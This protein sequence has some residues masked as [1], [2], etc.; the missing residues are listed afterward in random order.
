MI[1]LSLLLI[2]LIAGILCWAVGRRSG[3][4]ARWLALA[5]MIV[6]LFIT[7]VLTVRCQNNVLLLDRGGWLLE[8]KAPWI[9]QLGIGF[10]LAVDGISLLLIT[11]TA[12]LGLMVVIASW[13][14]IKDGV[15]FFHFNLLLT[16]AGIMGVFLSLDLFLFYFFWELMLV[17][18]FFLILS[19][20]HDERV[21][22]A[23]KFFIFTQFGGLLMLLSILGLAFAHKDAT[24]SLSFD[25]SAL[26]GTP[27]KGGT[28]IF[29]ILGFLAA[30]LVKLPAVPFH[31]WLP[32]AHTEAPTGGSVILAGL[33]LKTGAYGLIRFAVPLFPDAA[34]E[35][36][37]Y[38]IGLAVVGIIYGAVMAFS[39]TDLKRLIAYT[40]V[41]HMGFVLLGVCAWNT[42]ALQGVMIQIICHGV[43]TGALFMLAGALQERIHTRGLYRMGGLWQQV[44]RM[45]GLLLFFA[46]AAL[47][48]PGLGNFAG[49][50]LVLLGA[51]S[52]SIVGTI[53]AA[54]G[55]IFSTVYALWMAWR[56]LYGPQKETWDI[57]DLSA[58]EMLPLGVLVVVLI[59]IGLFPQTVINVAGQGYENVK[60]TMNGHISAQRSTET[61]EEKSMDRKGIAASEAGRTGVR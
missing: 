42:I 22:A 3:T 33:L 5:A 9:P 6:E 1:L 29:L 12:L 49:E 38:G 47:G 57:P 17:P 40:S 37:P 56:V 10:H 27:L 55:F 21:Y 20:G 50:F 41:S 36:A 7:V 13:T 58:R 11:L 61:F 8:V 59:W 23:V 44:P 24:G 32:D 19:W 30:F 46:L 39:Q 25:Y 18:M 31:S 51:Y 14:E 2:P 53:I 43:G 34:S 28:A 60:R 35:L 52:V 15:G 16:I 4:A 54:S 26:M 45:S 48:L